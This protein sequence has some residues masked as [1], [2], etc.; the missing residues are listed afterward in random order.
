NYRGDPSILKGLTIV[1]FWK[2]NQWERYPWR[3]SDTAVTRRGQRKDASFS[4]PQS[5]DRNPQSKI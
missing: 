2:H 1:C 4:N 5:A 3:G